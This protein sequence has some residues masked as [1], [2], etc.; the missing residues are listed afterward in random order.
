MIGG[1]ALSAF[2][3]SLPFSVQ[4]MMD[5]ICQEQFMEMGYLNGGQE[6][7]GRGGMPGRGRGGP[8]AAVH[9][10]GHIRLV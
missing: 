1:E 6:P 2:L 7:R 10:W 8:S 4:D 5:D 9:R 3:S